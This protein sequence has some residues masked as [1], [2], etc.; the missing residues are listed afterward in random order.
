LKLALLKLIFSNAELYPL[1]PQ[2]VT[3]QKPARVT[4][5]CVKECLKEFPILIVL[6]QAKGVLSWQLPLMVPTKNN[7]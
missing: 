4:V 7:R 5:A 1:D 2:Y 3:N 6:R